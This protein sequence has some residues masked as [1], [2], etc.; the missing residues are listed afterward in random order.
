[1]SLSGSAGVG[2]TFVTAKLIKAFVDKNY[3][4]LLTT[5]THK[6]LHVVKYMINSNNIHVN[7]TTLQSYLDLRL[8]TDYLRGTKV[9]NRNKKAEQFDYEKI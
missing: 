3:K 6:S 9:F 4:V 5:P 8:E 1:L 7:A 2:K